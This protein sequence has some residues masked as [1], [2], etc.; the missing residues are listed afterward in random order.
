MIIQDQF[1]IFMKLQT[2]PV[3]TF[4]TFLPFLTAH[5][6]QS[7]THANLGPIWYHLEPSDFPYSP[8]QFLVWDFFL[9]LLTTRELQFYVFVLELLCFCL[10]KDRILSVFTLLPV[11][12]HYHKLHGQRQIS[13]IYLID[14]QLTHHLYQFMYVH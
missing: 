1:G 10:I 5:R 3:E 8:N 12:L 4:E 13:D 9:T 14:I 2:S 7:V 11:G 6:L